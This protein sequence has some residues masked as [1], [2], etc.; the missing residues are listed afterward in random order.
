MEY[1]KYTVAKDIT[2]DHSQ[3]FGEFKV[4]QRK[5]M[6]DGGTAKDRQEYVIKL[7]VSEKLRRQMD[8]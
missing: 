8:L 5:D 3:G 4:T 7:K 6:A 1:L 2:Y